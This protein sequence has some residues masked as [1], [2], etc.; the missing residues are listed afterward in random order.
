MSPGANDPEQEGPA[1]LPDHGHRA[2]GR[3]KRQHVV[4]RVALGFVKRSNPA[5]HGPRDVDEPERR[6]RS[7]ADHPIGRTKASAVISGL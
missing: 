4:S 2:S 6:H 5:K 7:W 1:R 3:L